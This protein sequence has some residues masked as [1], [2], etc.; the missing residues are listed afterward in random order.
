MKVAVS[1][2]GRQEKGGRVLG[3]HLLAADVDVRV[4]GDDFV[5]N[6]GLPFANTKECGFLPF[7]R[8]FFRKNAANIFKFRYFL[9]DMFFSKLYLYIIVYCVALKRRR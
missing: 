6:L 9:S 2:E 4:R 5:A 7:F 1:D 8:R 3:Q